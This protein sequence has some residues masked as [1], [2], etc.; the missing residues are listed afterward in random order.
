[1]NKFNK[2]DWL[3]CI[4]VVL[5]MIALGL[6]IAHPHSV[7]FKGLLF[8]MEAALVGGVADWFAV[9]AL[10]KKP[11]GFSYHTD[12]IARKRESLIDSSIKMVQN[13][14]FSRKSLIVRLKGVRLTDLLLDWMDK[15]QGKEMLIGFCLECLEQSLRTIDIEKSATVVEKEIRQGIK[16]L[17][18][19]TLLVGLG[20]WITEQKKDEELFERMRLELSCMLEGEET[21]RKIIAYVEAYIE[22]QSQ[23]PLFAMMMMFAKSTDIINTEEAADVVQGELLKF[24]AELQNQ[25]HPLKLWLFKEMKAS[26]ADLQEDETWQKVLQQWQNGIADNINVHEEIKK[27]LQNIIQSC[28][29][30]NVAD[31]VNHH[32]TLQSPIVEMVT[33]EIEKY[34]NHLRKD[35]TIQSQVEV[36]LYDLAGRVVLQAQALLGVIVREVMK[37]LSNEQLN[38]LIYS[39]VEQDLIW[40]RMNGSIVGVL[41][42]LVLFSMMQIIQ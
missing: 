7:W 8:C 25:D 24:V 37:N 41:I 38:E 2:A 40:I 21:R 13:E 28:Q 1:M 3:L 6:K 17:P 26:A 16:G 30:E 20:A 34:L 22:E 4:V 19:Q 9:T 12:L 14:F 10:F 36:F 39:K 33:G 18:V 15:K 29:R 32:L 35:E 27:F 5:F 31:M 11:L 42:G 23:N